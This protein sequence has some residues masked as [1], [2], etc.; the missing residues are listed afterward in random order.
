MVALTQANLPLIGGRVV[1]P[2]Y[3]RA[4][5]TPGILHFGVGGFHRAHQAFYLDH[6]MNQGHSLDYGIIGVGLLPG[7]A[8]MRDILTAQ[9]YLY[10]LVTKDPS[11]E[12][13][14][15]IIGS[16]IGYLYG[17]D[18]PTAV[19]DRLADPAIRIVSLTI[20]EGGYN[21]DQVTGDFLTDNPAVQAE[22]VP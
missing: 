21:F 10:T 13:Q 14:A 1:V 22:L 3:D 20:T 5:V 11:G 16:V 19:I 8:R 9:D 12:W 7:D 15:R 6:I 2:G 17:P 4:A 18:N